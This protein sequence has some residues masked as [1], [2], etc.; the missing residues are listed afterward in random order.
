MLIKRTIKPKYHS[1]TQIV[2]DA[3]NCITHAVKLL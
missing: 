3:E 1:H 2:C